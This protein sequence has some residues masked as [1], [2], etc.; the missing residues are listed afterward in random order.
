MLKI[1]FALKN[2]DKTPYFII[3]NTNDIGK[4]WNFIDIKLAI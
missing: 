1:N 3:I 2:L 4:P